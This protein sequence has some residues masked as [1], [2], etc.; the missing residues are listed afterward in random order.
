MST[1]IALKTTRGSHL[2][3]IGDILSRMVPELKNFSNDTNPR[4][5]HLLVQTAGV[6][7]TVNENSDSDVE[8]DLDVALDLLFHTAAP[9]VDNDIV[10][11]AVGKT[12]CIPLCGMRLCLGTWQGVHL[13]D[14]RSAD[15]IESIDVTM[16]ATFLSATTS[17][18]TSNLMAPI[19]CKRNRGMHS[20]DALVPYGDRTEGLLHLWARHTSCSLACWVSSHLTANNHCIETLL[21]KVVPDTWSRNIF[22]HTAEGPDDM[23]AHV[24][25]TL[26]SPEVVLPLT[27]D[28]GAA[29]GD[30]D[31][32]G[33]GL[34]VGLCEHRNHSSTRRIQTT[35][36]QLATSVQTPQVLHQVTCSTLKSE[37]CTNFVF[38]DVTEIIKSRIEEAGA[39]TGVVYVFITTES[40]ALLLAHQDSRTLLGQL[41]NFYEKFRIASNSESKEVRSCES[42]RLLCA[43]AVTICLGVVKSLPVTK[44]AVV[45]GCELDVWVAVVGDKAPRDINLMFVFV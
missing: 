43:A 21:S 39:H 8:R 37:R 38:L 42:A 15:L 27:K 17:S 10:D 22:N 25:S 2:L 29:V 11:V 40:C 35:H 5:L 45:V 41:D 36:L 24:K 14:R 33:G 44:G 19:I 30:D 23:P 7:I 6:S 12:L 31:G 16:T 18:A 1:T 13:I 32:I 9:V 20:I 4:L 34:S 3:P 26:V 28:G